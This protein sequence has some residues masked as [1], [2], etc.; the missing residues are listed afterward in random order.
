VDVARPAQIESND[1]ADLTFGEVL[2]NYRRSSGLTQEEL[3]ERAGLSAR[4]VSG[5]ERGEGATPRRDTMALLVRALGLSGTDR[6]R[7][8]GMIARARAPRTA[9]AVKLVTAVD[10]GDD[11]HNL[12]RAINSFVGRERELAELAPLVQTAPLVTLVGAGGVGKT[13]LAQE[14]AWRAKGDF[15]DGVWFVQLAELSDASL[16]PSAIAAAVRLPDASVRKTTALLAD[17]LQHQHLLLVLDNCEHLVE[18]CAELVALLLQTCPNLHVLATSR[19]SLALMGEMIWPVEPLGLP[20]LGGSHTAAELA[21]TP[22]IHLFVDRANLLNPAFAVTDDNAAVLVRVCVAL[23]GIPLAVELA[24]ALTRVL[25]LEQ[26]AERLGCEGGVLHGSNNSAPPRQRSIRA[27]ID[28]S[29]ELL[30]ERDQRLLRRLA[31]FAGGWSLQTAEQLCAGSGS[32]QAGV[33]DVLA[34]LVDKSMVI[35]DASGRSAR[36]RLLEPIRQ[37]ALEQLQASGEADEFAARHAA[38][39]LSM[40]QSGASTDDYGPE[41]IA[42]LDRL[43]SEHANLRVGLRWAIDHGEADAGLRAAAMLFRFW[44]RR[45]HIQEGCAW[46]EEA[47]ATFRDVPSMYRGQALNA[48]GFLYWRLGNYDQAQAISE[49]GLVVNRGAPESLALAFALGNLGV[50]AYV[51]DEPEA[52]LRWLE[53]SVAISRRI[54]Y[55]PLLSVVLTFLGRSLLRLHGPADPRPTQVLHE[56]L[57]I[58]EAARARYAMGTAFLALGDVD[59]RRGAVGAAVLFWTRALE[60]QALMQDQPNIVATIERLAWGPVAADQLE[61]VISLFGAA[62]A[63]R[64]L[65]GITLRQELLIDHDER[66]A[67]ARSQF[68]GDFDGV[69]RR[70]EALSIREAVALALNVSNTA[71]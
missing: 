53:E 23:D 10:R 3:A 6:A 2:R 40:P 37:Y 14:L 44:E 31:V 45:G 20:D 66:L 24:A 1:P 16:V 39:M 4:S 28:W 11:Q 38:L 64:R 48:L 52:A 42:S 51:R 46:L 13:R 70:G 36:Y 15:A 62:H 61:S 21:H 26:I 56:S 25:S 49:Q 67:A 18:G 27:T 41:E 7:F 47:L 32:G 9:P 5:W 19:E 50:I 69:W 59:W 12:G 29:Y 65:L 63:Q 33:L 60:V 30:D 8:E 58:A 35:A 57:A 17:Y 71:V 34:R 55:G 68:Q 54:G 43:E 22:A